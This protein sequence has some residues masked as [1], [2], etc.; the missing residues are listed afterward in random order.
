ME[1][2]NISKDNKSEMD[3][4]SLK[5]FILQLK[6]LTV[7]L[8]S[9]WNIILIFVIL[10]GVLGFIYSYSKTP[11]YSAT[12]TFVLDNGDQNNTLRS[13]GTLATI[14][15]IDIAGES[16]LF[17]QDNIYDLYRSR[18]MITRALLSKVEIKGKKELLIDRY[19]DQNN[20]RKKWENLP[21]LS[22]ISFDTVSFSRLQDSI[23]GTIVKD[24]DKNYLEVSRPDQGNSV[25]KVEVKSHDEIFS[26][27]FDEQLVKN[28][29]EFYIQT[30]TKKSLENLAILQKKTD[31]IRGAMNE[32][33]SSA[34]A[35]VDKTPNLNP[36]RQSERIVPVQRSQFNSETNKAILTELVKNLELIKMNL[37]RETPLIQVIDEP[38]YPLDKTSFGKLK[39]II[40]GAALFGF[41]CC[42]FLLIRKLLQKVLNNE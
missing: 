9:K 32:N 36:T 11:V 34:A 13:L 25:T 16:G 15:G 38:I 7:Y 39:G 12:T 17:Q 31:S 8:L 40:L 23:I 29:N 3:K 37:L 5:E 14:A 26:K 28:V 41:L 42:V 1:N 22:H 24:I 6:G 4:I 20:L 35:T 18:S 27:E 10:G 2:R 21:T 19:I 33:I 30:K